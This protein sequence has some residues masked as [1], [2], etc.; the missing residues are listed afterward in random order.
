MLAAYFSV[1]TYAAKFEF[2]KRGTYV[3]VARLFARADLRVAEVDLV[4]QHL[5]IAHFLLHWLARL[6]A[7]GT[8]RAG[9]NRECEHTVA[10]FRFHIYF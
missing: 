8:A 3:R 5:L 1:W 4:R 7:Y 10:E 6:A 9:L 2:P